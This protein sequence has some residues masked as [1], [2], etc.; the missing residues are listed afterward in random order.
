MITPSSGNDDGRKQ[1][2]SYIAGGSNLAIFI[3]EKNVTLLP[4]SN[5][6]FGSISIQK[7]HFFVEVKE[8]LGKNL[9][10]SKLGNTS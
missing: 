4:L 9:N 5:P 2:H 8:L 7:S 10:I 6:L 3:K 1:G